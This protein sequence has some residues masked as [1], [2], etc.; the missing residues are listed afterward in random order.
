MMTSNTWCLSFK[1]T[2]IYITRTLRVYAISISNCAKGHICVGTWNHQASTHTGLV[3]TISS[4]LHQVFTRTLGILRPTVRCQ[5]CSYTMTPCPL[6]RDVCLFQHIC[7]VKLSHKQKF[8][9]GMHLVLKIGSIWE[10]VCVCVC[11][12]VCVSMCVCTCMHVHVCMCV[13]IHSYIATHTIRTSC[14]TKVLIVSN[15]S[16]SFVA[17]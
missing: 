4:G 14:V 11:V 2:C 5:H 1:P 13:F 6:L 15:Y 12:C 10:V 8:N 3:H 16:P 17:Q 7:V 9:P